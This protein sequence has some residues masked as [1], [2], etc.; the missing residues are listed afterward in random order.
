MLLVY[1]DRMLAALQQVHW[2]CLVKKKKSSSSS[3]TGASC[4][5]FAASL[6]AVVRNHFLVVMCSIAISIGH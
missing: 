4:D 2:M 5:E 6:V 1:V 3:E